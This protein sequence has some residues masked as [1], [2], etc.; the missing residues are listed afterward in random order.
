MERFPMRRLELELK[1]FILPN[2]Q[3]VSV[4]AVR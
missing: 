2:V 1:K 3:W 4:K